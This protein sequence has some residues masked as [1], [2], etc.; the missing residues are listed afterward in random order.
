MHNKNYVHP[1]AREITI[2]I[3]KTEIDVTMLNVLMVAAILCFE[4]AFHNFS[5]AI[6]NALWSSSVVFVR[7][8][9]PTIMLLSLLADSTGHC[10]S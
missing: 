10:L 3:L 8:G 7:K 9:P 2:K 6:K 4:A 1:V 5:V